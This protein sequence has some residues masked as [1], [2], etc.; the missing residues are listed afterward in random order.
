[1]FT[2]H[3]VVSRFGQS[4]RNTLLFV[5]CLPITLQAQTGPQLASTLTLSQAVQLSQ[6]YSQQMAAQEAAAQAARHMAVVAGQLP[7]LTLKLGVN[8]LPVSGSDQFSLTS[9]FMTMQ[10]VGVMR[11]FTRADKR[12]ART[13]RF[14]RE[15]EVADANRDLA[16]TYLQRDTATAWLERHFQE[17]TLDL[18]QIQRTE[19]ALQVEAAEAAFRGGRGS[20]ADVFAA[21]SAVAWIDDRMQ[22]TQ[23][24]VRIA[25]TRLVRWVGPLGHQA[26]AASPDLSVLAIN[27]GR[28]EDFL[29]AHPQA[30]VMA[31]QEAAA[32][33]EADIVRSEKKADWTVELMVNQ[34]GPAYSNMA[35]INFSVPLQLNQGNRQDREL[36]AKLA[37]VQQMQAQREEAQRERSAQIRAWLM[38]WQGNRERLATFDR[39]LL[40]LSQQRTQAALTAYRGN[41]NGGTLTTV[42]EARRMHIDARMDQ[43]RLEM[44]T[45]GLWAQLNYLVTDGN[46]AALLTQSVS[47]K[48]K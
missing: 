7:E 48:G 42:L 5:L 31:R 40:P 15:A 38:Q 3:F 46:L 8:N 20:Q 24:Q 13:A 41:G 25:T 29:Q 16:Q 1:M 14:E 10:S 17:R 33:A 39:I 11:E 19:A 43:L 9:D 35:S 26:L 22:Q 36:A 2:S 12:Q 6:Q 32:R 47:A 34:R 27:T 37:L 21:R 28:L 4:A 44:E 45:A 23:T 18:L 30:I